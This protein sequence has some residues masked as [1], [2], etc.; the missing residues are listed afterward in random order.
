MLMFVADKKGEG[1]EGVVV[2]VVAQWCRPLG[3]DEMRDP[4]GNCEN[5]G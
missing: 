5:K 2:V 1:K 4:G 3:S